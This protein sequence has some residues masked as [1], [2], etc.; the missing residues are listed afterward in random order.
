MKPWLTSITDHSDYDALLLHIFP[1]L[2]VLSEMERYT[3]VSDR[4]NRLTEGR[5][6]TRADGMGATRCGYDKGCLA[7]SWKARR[8]GWARYDWEHLLVLVLCHRVVFNSLHSSP[9]TS[10]WM[11]SSSSG[12]WWPT[13]P[14]W[15]HPPF[16]IT[17]RL[18]QLI[19]VLFAAYPCEKLISP[20]WWVQGK[21][22]GKRS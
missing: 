18:V 10:D 3:V 21:K 11:S 13:P 8:E 5:K 7:V 20:H 19:K 14:R 16:P 22:E 17:C 15:T 12:W 4:G 6:G 9:G 2:K 1:F